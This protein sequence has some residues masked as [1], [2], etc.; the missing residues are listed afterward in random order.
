MTEILVNGHAGRSQAEIADSLG[1]DR[2]TVRKYTAPAIA[3]G[4]VPGGAPLGD[5]EWIALATGIV[6]LTAY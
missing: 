6:P 3:A 2:K 4:L 1:M 5:A